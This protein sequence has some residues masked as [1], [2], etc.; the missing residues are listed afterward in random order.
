M[1]IAA[2]AILLSCAAFVLPS[3]AGTPKAPPKDAKTIFSTF[4]LNHDGRISRNEF[5]SQVRNR[6][7]GEK[8]FNE[9]DANGDGYISLDEAM[10]KEALMQEALRLTEPPPLR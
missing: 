6:K 1:R 9:L 2:L 8:L 3:C 4:D 7:A 10:A 5:L